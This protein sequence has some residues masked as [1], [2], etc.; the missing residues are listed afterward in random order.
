MKIVS[1]LIL[2]LAASTFAR[3]QD[4][5]QTRYLSELV[6]QSVQTE[7]DTLQNFYRANQSANTENILSRMSGVYLIRRS[8][9]GQ[10]P[11]IRGMSAGQINVTIDGMRMFS[12]CTDKMD[13]VTIY[14]EPQNLQSINA[15]LG[16]NGSAVGNTIGGSLDL[17]LAEP[18][19]S[20]RKVTGRAGT[21][22]QSVSNGLNYF[23]DTNL[24]GANSAY[25]ASI[26]YRKNH[27][28]RDGN[29]QA[30]NF[31]QFEKVNFSMAGKWQA[32]RD[33][34][35]AN[36]LIDEGKNIGFPALPMD[37]GKA[38]ATLYALSFT[39]HRGKGWLRNFEAK[40]YANE[41]YHQM[42]DSQREVDMHMDMP[43]WSSTYGAYTK[44]KI[45]DLKNHKL[46][47]RTDL[48][49]NKVLAEMV[50]YPDNGAPM[51]MQTWPS[52]HRTV[53][54]AYLADDIKLSNRFKM[55][56]NARLDI[57]STAIKEGFG[58]NQLEVFY[59]SFHSSIYN[60]TKT[61]NA[62]I[63][64]PF[65]SNFLFTL[66]GGY[67]ER[68]PSNA[69]L[70]GFYLFNRQD[71]HDY[72]GNPYLGTEQSLTSDIGIAFFNTWLEVS[73][74]LFYQHSPEY[75]LAYIDNALDAMTPGASGAKVYKNIPYADFWGAEL[76]M[77]VA[78]TSHVQLVG[79]FKGT[80]AE[81]FD[82]DPL[83]FIP[84]YKNVTSVRYKGN[85]FSGQVEW[86]GA[87]QQSHVSAH[88]GE[89]ATPGY[90]IF[91]LRTNHSWASRKGRWQIGLGVENLA[92]AYYREHLDWGGLPR[93]GRNFYCTLVA[94]F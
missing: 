75:I 14:V 86:E 44:G 18:V 57:A 67:G 17:R 54:G 53:A 77:L 30:V 19:F 66:H 41:V 69:E 12:A 21:G 73:G 16:T 2:I 13:P 39:R 29:G 33:T 62:T 26:I 1:Y 80:R 93:P 34:I 23:T 35:K 43:G 94:T 68:L 55:N 45:K 88:F 47:F 84:A 10:E 72:L 65:F 70:F 37:V 85:K 48:Y 74:T 71:N 49:H 40:V 5:L 90:S 27:N 82:G 63:S 22:Y 24:T 4:T 78:P 81:A 32:K 28:Y 46:Q 6:I 89:K 25:R 38:R 15:S 3:A 61:L 76:A 9:Y 64:K 83:P 7:E 79:N 51:Y 20:T 60:I 52:S 91:N 11:V 50:M 42:D 92:N 8:A 87:L 59:P 36:F 58:K 56:I 31:S